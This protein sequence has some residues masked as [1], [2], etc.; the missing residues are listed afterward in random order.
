[1]SLPLWRTIYTL[2]FSFRHPGP[3]PVPVSSR[4]QCQCLAEQQCLGL[5]GTDP[6]READFLRVKCQGLWAPNCLPTDSPAVRCG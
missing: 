3:N 5:E 1:M 2:V 4:G 6:S